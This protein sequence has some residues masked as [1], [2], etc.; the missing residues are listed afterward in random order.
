MSD[1]RNGKRDKWEIDIDPDFSLPDEDGD[2][3]IGVTVSVGKRDVGLKATR[4]TNPNSGVVTHEGVVGPA[5]VTVEESPTGDYTRSGLDLGGLGIYG[6]TRTE[7]GRKVGFEG[8]SVFG[9]SIGEHEY[10]DIHNPN[11]HARENLN[12]VAPRTSWSQ[13]HGRDLVTND[14]GAT[15]PAQEAEHRGIGISQGEW[16]GGT[17]DQDWTP[18]QQE[19]RDFRAAHNDGRNVNPGNVNPRDVGLPAPSEVPGAYGFGDGPDRLRAERVRDMSEAADRQRTADAAQQQ[20]EAAE[21]A[22]RNR[23]AEQQRNSDGGG[24]DESGGGSGPS[25]PPSGLRS[26]E[27]GRGDSGGGSDSG[28]DR[29]DG[30]DDGYGGGSMGGRPIVIDLNRDGRISL[31]AMGQSTALFDFDGDGF[32]HRTGWVTP[33]DGLLAYDKDGDGA[34]RHHDELSFVGYHPGARTNLEGLRGFDSNHDGMLSAADANWSKFRV[35]RDANSNGISEE[36]E[37]LTLASHGLTSLK[38]SG[39]G[40]AR[41]VNGNT[42]HHDT[43]FSRDDG[44]RTT[45]WD[46]EF[47]LSQNQVRREGY[48]DATRLMVKKPDGSIIEAIQ[49]RTDEGVNIDLAVASRLT[50]VAGSAHGDTVS[51]PGNG[52]SDRDVLVFGGGG[53]D[54]IAG[55]NGNDVIAGNAGADRLLGGGGND[56]V[57]FDGDDVLVDGGSGTDTAVWTGSGGARIEVVS[58]P[59]TS[60][61]DNARQLVSFENV[62][63]GSGNDHIHSSG[64]H[65]VTLHG[66]GGDDWLF[67]GINADTLNGGAGN[68]RLISLFGGDNLSGG[69]GQDIL[70]VL[71]FNAV[72]SGG[73]GRDVFMFSLG[74]DS[75][76][77]ANVVTDFT[78]RGAD[79][80]LLYILRSSSVWYRKFD[81]DNDGDTDTV[82]YNN[83]AGNGGIHGILLD[84]DDTLTRSNF[85]QDITVTEIA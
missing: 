36:G 27:G 62:I 38:L 60:P 49:F 24:R 59:S 83:A 48:D 63:G 47:G 5:T 52:A 64:L 69:D 30:P 51:Y 84:Y 32:A 26:E 85:V 82:L 42:I 73:S 53:D 3:S 70:F 56:V 72:L 58:R 55:G 68:D 61:A 1:N 18:S 57:M 21:A 75:I 50:A 7:N 37:L 19:I 79:R 9:Q 44:G 81:A 8:V 76:D 74:T 20:R 31:V 46:V 66:M 10:T 78:G 14:D 28:G 41:T 16:Q 2:Y 67:G 6:G 45:A 17:V 39:T 71:S 12:P 43:F 65:A 25:G 29:S 11:T 22:A 54:R 23:A 13:Q 15:P 34:I 4:T 35:W 77:R 33:A 80:D 40:P